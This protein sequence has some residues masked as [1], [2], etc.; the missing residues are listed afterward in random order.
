MGIFGKLFSAYMKKEKRPFCS[1]IIV[2]AGQSRRMGGE[3]KIFSELC[4]S[5]VIIH[6]LMAF[7]ESDY[8]DEII[9][10]ARD[11]AIARIADICA[12]K[13]LNKV[14]KIVCGGEKRIDSVLIGVTEASSE[15]ELLAIHDGARP[16]V[17]SEIIAGTVKDAVRFG[18]AAPA[19]SVHD[20]LKR[21]K[22]G[23][24][25][26]T[27]DRSEIFAVQTPQVFRSSVIKAALQNAKTKGQ[28]VTDDCMAAEA[29]GVSIKLSQGSFENIKITTPDDLTVAEAIIRKRGLA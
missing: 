28:N 27:V 17:T 8:I 20:T 12:E 6:T 13:N 11:E 3:D 22:N 7:Q 25:T 14:M 29:M 23:I 19:V 15:A 4:G 1:A 9:V 24:I 21:A 26:E 10:V 18:A 2:A 16:L 5:P